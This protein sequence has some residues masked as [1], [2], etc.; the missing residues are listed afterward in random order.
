MQIIEYLIKMLTSSVSILISSDSPT[1]SSQRSSQR[2]K[3]DY[4]HMM[5]VGKYFKTIDDFVNVEMVNKKYKEIIL[6]YKY[7]PIPLT[8][9]RIRKLFS[10]IET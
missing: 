7:N 5:V 1:D 6:R 8:N 10:N 4:F 2:G 3:I 9:E